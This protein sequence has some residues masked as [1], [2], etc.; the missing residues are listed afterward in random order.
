MS[1]ITRVQMLLLVLGAIAGCG[2]KAESFVSVSAPE[3]AKLLED[4]ATFLLDVRTHEEYDS[5][6]LAQATLVPLHELEGRLAELPP[7]KD[8]P[9][10]IYC[11]SGNRSVSAATILAKH[12]YT[13]VFNMKGGIKEGVQ[14]KL[15]VN[16][17]KGNETP[18][19][20]K[21]R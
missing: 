3:S 15:P 1:L 12:G 10:L 19:L 18:G 14:H 2:V 9:F 21:E 13:K 20:R 4:P 7:Q 17:K 16:M 6:H 8:R 11:R 5:G